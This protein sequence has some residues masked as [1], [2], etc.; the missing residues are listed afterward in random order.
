MVAQKTSNNDWWVSVNNS[1]KTLFRSHHY[2]ACVADSSSSKSQDWFRFAVDINI[3]T[4]S[5]TLNKR[6]SNSVDLWTNWK[7]KVI[8]GIVCS[9]DKRNLISLP[10]SAWAHLGEFHLNMK[11]MPGCNI[12]Q[13]QN[14]WYD[15][16]VDS[17]I[18]RNLLG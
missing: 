15:K 9:S 10:C 17:R 18:L 2:A 12:I 3:S 14:S 4:I 11:L 13:D 6:K 16:N 1:H 8:W 5:Q 7:L